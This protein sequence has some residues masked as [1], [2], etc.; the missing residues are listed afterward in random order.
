[1]P[2]KQPPLHPG[3][4]LREEFLVPFGL[5]PSALAEA[6]G[7]PRTHVERIAAETSG[8]TTDTT[9]RQSKTLSTPMQHGDLE[10]RQGSTNEVLAFIYSCSTALT[11][12]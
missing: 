12:T 11:V 7:V 4:T 9:L 1:M 10:T 5:S 3:E 6:M 2:K 8:I